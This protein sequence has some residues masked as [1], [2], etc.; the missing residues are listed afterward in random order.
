MWCY[1]KKKYTLFKPNARVDVLCYS[2]NKHTLFKLNT[3][4]DLNKR[5]TVIPCGYLGWTVV[6]KSKLSH[7]IC[8]IF[9]KTKTLNDLLEP[10]LNKRSKL[11]HDVKIQTLNMTT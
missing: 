10:T 4:V 11:L 8:A 6:I 7:P 9:E 5:Y 3:R 1:S 2:M